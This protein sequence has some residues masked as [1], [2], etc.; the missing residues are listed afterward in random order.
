V[1]TDDGE[2]IIGYY[3]L[4]SHSVDIDA[5]NAE[6]AR[7]RLRQHPIPAVLL[8]RLAVAVEYQGNRLGERLLADFVRRVVKASNSIGIALLVVD[9]LD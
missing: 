5:V 3:A 6:L 9:A 4:S 8:A 1:L 2:T 7:G